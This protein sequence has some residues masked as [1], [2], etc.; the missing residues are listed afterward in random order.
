MRAPMSLKASALQWLTLRE[1]SR[2][3]LQ[4]KLLRKARKLAALT[5]G[6]TEDTPAPAVL[7]EVLALLDELQAK[8]LLSEARF[9]ESRVHARSARFGNRRIEA[10]LGRHRL[11]LDADISAALRGTEPQRALAVWQRRY[12]QPPV[13]ARERQKQMRFLM[14]RGFSSDAIR[15]VFSQLPDRADEDEPDA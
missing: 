5:Q 3:E 7:P 8:G 10:E 11:T 13:D 9:V 12:G 15:H 6:E 14:G 2:S 1:H 4:A